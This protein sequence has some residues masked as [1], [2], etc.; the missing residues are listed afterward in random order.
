MDGQIDPF[1]QINDFECVDLIIYIFFALSAHVSRVIYW[2]LFDSYADQNDL[3]NLAPDF[4]A[5]QPILSAN[6]INYCDRVTCVPGLFYDFYTT[7][8]YTLDEARQ[9]LTKIKQAWINENLRQT[10]VYFQNLIVN[11]I[12]SVMPYLNE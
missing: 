2:V 10:D 5:I 8:N 9:L 6:Q 3:F 4:A 12:Y 7:V 1:G 11:N